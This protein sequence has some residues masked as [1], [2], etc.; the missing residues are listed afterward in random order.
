MVEVAFLGRQ[1][2]E[3][4]GLPTAP[5]PVVVPCELVLTVEGDRITAGY[6]TF[7]LDELRREV[8]ASSP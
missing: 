5:R 1:L 2:G 8:G 7:D 3:F 4:F 6:V